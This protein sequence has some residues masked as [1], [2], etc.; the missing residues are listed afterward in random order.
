MVKRIFI[1]SIIFILMIIGISLIIWTI[2]QQIY[3]PTQ[4]INST[5]T[6]IFCSAFFFTLPYIIRYYFY[7][8][9]L[10]LD[11]ENYRD[12]LIQIY[13]TQSF[14]QTP[15]N[16]EPKRFNII[17]TSEREEI[18][19]KSKYIR[20]KLINK[21]RKTAENCKI[22]IHIFKPWNEKVHE[23][24]Y[25]YPSGYHRIKKNRELPP[26][27]SIAPK[28]SQIFDICS[29]NNLW[30]N[31]RLIRFED[32]FTYSTVQGQ[33][34][35]NFLGKYYIKLFVYSD[36]NP[37]FEKQYCIFLNEI[38]KG[39]DWEKL[40][41]KEYDWEDKNKIFGSL[42]SFFKKII[43]RF[44]RDDKRMNNIKLNDEG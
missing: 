21:G 18:K 26:A 16:D 10:K 12:E 42:N 29:S 33:D 30:E 1:S 32:Y 35:L 25:L 2:I 3:Y 11:L 24:S 20:I 22:K 37:P 39:L 27:V 6:T 15:D 34:D 36:N 9:N 8:P 7:Q 40:D 13:Q 5:L 43:A 44:K 4:L 14:R 41:I 19:E 23:E 17:T 28:D 31:E 38:I